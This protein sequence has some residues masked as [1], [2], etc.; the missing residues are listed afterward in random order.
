MIFFWENNIEK[1]V[2]YAYFKHNFN[3]WRSYGCGYTKITCT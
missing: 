2:L 1:T 3:L